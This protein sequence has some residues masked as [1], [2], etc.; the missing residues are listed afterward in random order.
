MD[1]TFLIHRWYITGLILG[2]LV[3]VFACNKI[4]AGKNRTKS[5]DDFC[6]FKDS[7]P[8][9]SVSFSYDLAHPDR[10][11]ILPAVL[12]EISG[13]CVYDSLRLAA[14]QDEWG[15]VF[16]LRKDDGTVEKRIDFAEDGDYE[17]ITFAKN[18]IFV[19]NS[20]GNIYQIDQN[21]IRSHRSH[22]LKPY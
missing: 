17:D 2:C 13:I 9:G 19:L 14:I 12:D 21:I 10:K 6:V 11:L 3:L 4:P 20:N 7:V 16:I 18:K 1:L 8:E 5:P 15:R 22:V